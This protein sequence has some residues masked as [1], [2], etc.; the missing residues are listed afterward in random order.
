M[1]LDILRNSEFEEKLT[2]VLNNT[3]QYLQEKQLELKKVSLTE[4]VQ[5]HDENG[6]RKVYVGE[7][8]PKEIYNIVLNFIK[9]EF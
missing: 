5:W 2:K 3:E 4:L 8:C 6:I 1:N 7:K 9:E